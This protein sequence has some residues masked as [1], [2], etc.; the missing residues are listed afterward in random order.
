M[1][2]SSSAAAVAPGSGA[3]FDRIARRYDLLNRILS[4]GMD[5]RWRGKAAAALELG[6]G[7]RVPLDAVAGADGV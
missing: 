4:L 5:R 3:M 2:Q 7:A 1:R 6:A